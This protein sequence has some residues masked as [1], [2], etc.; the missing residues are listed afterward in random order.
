ML[1]NLCGIYNVESEYILNKTNINY[2]PNYLT[3]EEFLTYVYDLI[4]NLKTL[5]KN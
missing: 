5:T 4:Y 1:R 2:L 3:S